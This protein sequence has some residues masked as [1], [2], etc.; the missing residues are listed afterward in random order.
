MS[1]AILGNKTVEGLG[2]FIY[3]TT[4]TAF[5]VA[6]IR[7]SI[8]AGSGLS[9]LIKQNAS[10]KATSTAPTANSVEVDLSVELDITS[11]DTISFVLS[12]STA[13]DQT[14]NVLK[15]TLNVHLGTLN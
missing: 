12:S 9:V 5:H 11:G 15:S 14:P 3:T 7:V 6:S 2:T 13:V 10:T 1:T 8:P 4:V